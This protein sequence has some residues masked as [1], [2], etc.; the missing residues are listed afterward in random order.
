MENVVPAA[1]PAEAANH[2]VGAGILLL[3][4]PGTDPRLRLR[5]DVDGALGLGDDFAG[6]GRQEAPVRYSF[7]KARSYALLMAGPCGAA[8]T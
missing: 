7:S 5:Q 1:L 8:L 6:N 2:L 3:L 4:D